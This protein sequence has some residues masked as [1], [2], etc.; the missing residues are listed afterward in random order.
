M[1]RQAENSCNLPDGRIVGYGL[2]PP[3]ARSGYYRVRFSCDGRRVE[4]STGAESK[5][6]ARNRA[7]AII[8]AEFFPEVARPAVTGW[9]E[10]MD[11]LAALP[12]LR[13][14]TLRSYGKAVKAFRRVVP[15]STGPADVTADT[16][17]LFVTKYRPKSANTVRNVLRHLSS[18]WAKHFKALKLAVGNPWSEIAPPPPVRKN[19]RAPS[20]EEVREFLTYLEARYPAWELP[21]LFVTLKGYLG[22]R[23]MDAC[24]LRSDQLRDGRIHF[25]PDQTKAR[26][27][28]SIPLPPEMVTALDRLKGPKFLWERFPADAST[29]RKNP[30]KTNAVPKPFAPE[31][32]YSFVGNI[33]AEFNRSRPDKPRFRPHDLRRLALTQA[34]LLFGAQEAAKAIGVDPQT[35]RRYYIDAEKTNTADA[36]Y[37][38]LAEW[39][40]Y[41]G[42]PAD[43]SGAASE[44]SP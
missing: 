24:S 25:D 29:Y 14:A 40:R 15:D 36:V 37:G 31:A 3:K 44:K 33:F 16:A 4:K 11:G 38:K 9:D 22:C 28:R 30:N 35:A 17:Q 41:G 39:W 5:G 10:A 32:L 6:E 8:R 7:P 20:H 42:G 2:I 43:G 18:L 13:P 1:G 19:P 26:V 23:T 34:A 21:R 27:G 12:H